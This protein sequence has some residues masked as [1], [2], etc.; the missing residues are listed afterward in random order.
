[1]HSSHGV[2]AGRILKKRKAKRLNYTDELDMAVPLEPNHRTETKWM[3]KLE[4]LLH[5]VDDGFCLSKSIMRTVAV[6]K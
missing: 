6:L 4:D 1:M 2:N 5:F 3:Q